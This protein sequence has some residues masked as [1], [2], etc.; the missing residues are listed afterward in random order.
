MFIVYGLGPDFFIGRHFVEKRKIDF[1]AQ[2]EVHH[3]DAVTETEV[4]LQLRMLLRNLPEERNDDVVPKLGR[5]A[6]VHAAR[7]FVFFGLNL[8]KG[9]FER[10]EAF[11]TLFV[12]EGGVRRRNDALINAVKERNAD[13]IFE[14]LDVLTD[15]ALGQME[16]AGGRS[17]AL[18]AID[19]LENPN[20]VQVELINNHDQQISHLI[21]IHDSK[22]PIFLSHKTTLK[23]RFRDPPYPPGLYKSP[24]NGCRRSKRRH[25][26]S[27]GFFHDSLSRSVRASTVRRTT[28]QSSSDP[29]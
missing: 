26:N 2:D 10:R 24:E 11:F 18:G 9:L 16:L 21:I 1:T 8:G 13:K 14:R 25:L 28:Q 29:F 20:L 7:E 3:F 15:P 4:K 27:L 5:H 23:V 6:D 12:E 17:H 22:M 19:A